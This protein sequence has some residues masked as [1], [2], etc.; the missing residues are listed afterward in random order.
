MSEELKNKDEAAIEPAAAAAETPAKKDKKTQINELIELG[1][2]KGKLTTQ[3]I[4]D[5]L[6]DL[7]FDP[8]QMDKLYDS[9]E[10]QNIEIIDD[11]GDAAFDDL[12]LVLEA[13]ES[14]D[15]QSAV[16]AH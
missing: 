14:E 13:P 2:N 9:L 8:E 16:N 1:K 3:E 15:A 4:L 12:D 6:E 7:D 11:F 10:S 5:A